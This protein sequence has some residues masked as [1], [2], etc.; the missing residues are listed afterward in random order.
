MDGA[1][2]RGPATSAAA[3]A[4]ALPVRIRLRH[5]RADCLHSAQHESSVHALVCTCAHLQHSLHTLARTRTHASCVHTAQEY[6]RTHATHPHTRGTHT[7]THARTRT[8]AHTQ[9]HTHTHARARVRTHTQART[10]SLERMLRPHSHL[11]FRDVS[12]VIS[13]NGPASETAPAAPN[14]LT[15]KGQ[16]QSESAAGRLQRYPSQPSS[17]SRPP[18]SSSRPLW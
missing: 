14:R 13:A 5:R 16:V 9:T 6:T 17:L 12:L 18:L 8:Q 1:D 15:A 10:Q 2:L 4:E 11:R 7:H 3:D